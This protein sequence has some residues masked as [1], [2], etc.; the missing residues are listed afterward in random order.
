M[1]RISRIGKEMVYNRQEDAHEFLISLLDTME[2][3]FYAELGGKK[4]YDQRSQETTL[5]HHMFSSY[6]RNGIACCKCGCASEVL[7]NP[8]QVSNFHSQCQRSHSLLLLCPA[9]E[10]FVW[11]GMV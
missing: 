11:E 1:K 9:C 4:Q 10:A 5:T 7:P 6:V 2:G 3:I 8:M